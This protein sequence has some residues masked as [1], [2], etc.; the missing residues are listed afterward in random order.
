M[1]SLVTHGVLLDP[2][3]P[4]PIELRPNPVADRITMQRFMGLFVVVSALVCAFS[5]LQGNVLAP[6]FG[7]LNLFLLHRVLGLVRQQSNA[8]D[9]IWFDGKLIQVQQQRGGVVAERG[10][11][12]FWVRLS[13]SEKRGDLRV[14]LASHGRR[15]EVGRF[16][17]ASRKQGLAA[18]LNRLIEHARSVVLSR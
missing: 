1:R 16:L 12:P 15:V 13:Q 14:F 18:D 3:W 4:T 8:S 17:A 9:R 11:D 10:F 2:D 7:L 5:F 6:A